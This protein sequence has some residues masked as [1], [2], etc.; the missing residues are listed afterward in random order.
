MP[1]EGKDSDAEL[2][3]W[4]TRGEM[5]ERLQA[6]GGRLVVRPLTRSATGSGAIIPG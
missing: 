5:H 4:G 6:G 1:V 2:E 3:L